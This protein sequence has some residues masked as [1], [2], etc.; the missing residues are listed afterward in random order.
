MDTFFISQQYVRHDVVGTRP[1][2]M[3]HEERR[4]IIEAPFLDRYH[5]PLRWGGAVTNEA[6]PAPRRAPAP[7]DQ[8]IDGNDEDERD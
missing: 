5:Q 8:D 2:L 3:S 6:H 1:P 7:P 4:K